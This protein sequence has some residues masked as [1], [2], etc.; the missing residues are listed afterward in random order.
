MAATV[1]FLTHVVLLVLAI[2]AVADVMITTSLSE[3]LALALL[4]GPLPS[5]Q[6]S[7]RIRNLSGLMGSVTDR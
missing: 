7:D 4:P 6:V 1:D 5:P 2:L 3:P